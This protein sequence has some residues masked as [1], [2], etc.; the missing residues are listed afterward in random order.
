MKAFKKK[1]SSSAQIQLPDP[2]HEY[3]F[4]VR[5][6][7]RMDDKYNVP[8]D[9]RAEFLAT[10]V[11]N[12]YDTPI[13]K[14]GREQ[15]NQT[16]EEISKRIDEIVNKHK[17]EL[18]I[19]IVSSPFTRCLMTASGL[20]KT[21][22]DKYKS[23]IGGKIEVREQLSELLAYKKIEP[24]LVETLPIN[25][26]NLWD[27]LDPFCELETDIKVS[28]PRKDGPKDCFKV[29]YPQP[30]DL[31]HPRYVDYIKRANRLEF[32]KPKGPKI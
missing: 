1:Y 31:A 9:E 2:L 26:G 18:E 4:V 32:Q 14:N 6:A 7:E 22:N 17:C 25:Q 21:M 29:T 12:E 8:Q 20:L 30:L 10:Y 13:S 28:N 23:L 5:H 27:H 15:A 11:I 24:N 19:K 3:F 16:G